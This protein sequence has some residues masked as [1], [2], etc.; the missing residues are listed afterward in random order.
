M[1]CYRAD[2]YSYSIQSTATLITP[3]RWFSKRLYAS[4]MRRSVDLARPD[5]P[6]DLGAVA[7]IHIIAQAMQISFGL[8]SDLNRSCSI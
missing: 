6:E 1:K 8:S 7:A 4:A 2:T 5:Q 3:S